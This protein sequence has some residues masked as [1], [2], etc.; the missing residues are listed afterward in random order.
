M[1][2]NTTRFLASALIVILT[3][4]CFAYNSSVLD[5]KSL[6]ELDQVVAQLDSLSDYTIRLHGHTDNTGTNERNSQLS[7]D[8]ALAVR[9]YLISKNADSTK[10]VFEF[11]GEEKPVLPNT[12]QENMALNRRVEVTVTGEK[13]I[14]TEQET[15]PYDE[16]QEAITTEK[17][18]EHIVTPIK[19]EI[20]KTKKHRHLV[21]TG[22]RTGF[23]W[24]TAGR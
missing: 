9:N 16:P 6:Q 5:E 7:K 10:I 1:K 11:Y 15:I 17:Q 8:R 13:I 3:T 4:V 23:H 18:D 22:W 19:S 2:K 24:S 12:T 20:K 21:W 14:P